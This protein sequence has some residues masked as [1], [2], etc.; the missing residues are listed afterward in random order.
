MTVEKHQQAETYLSQRKLAAAYEICQQILAKSPNF[1]PAYNTQGKILQA[2]GKIESAIAS[3]RQ[4]IKLNPHQIETYKILGDILVEQKQL[5]QAIIWYKTAIKFHP[6]FSL[7]YHKLGSV[8]M[9]Q[10][11]WDEAVDAF[12]RA[13]QLNPNFAWSYQ[14]LGEALAQQKKWHQAV[15]AYQRAIEIKPDLDGSYRHLGNALIKQGKINEAIAYYQDSIKRQPN[16][17]I[18]HKLLADALE[19]QG[20]L[21]AAITSYLRAIEL[22]PDSPWSHICLWKVL[23]KKD[24]WDEAVIIY[25]QAIEFNP[26]G[27]WLW[28]YL[29]NALVKQGKLEAAITCYQKA[30]EL[31]PENS[32]I[33]RFLADAFVKNNQWEAAANAYLRAIQINPE[34]SWADRGL[35]S[36]FKTLENANKFDEAV[37]L[38]RQKIA[39]NPESVLSYINLGEILTEQ[40]KINQAI[41]CYQT[42]CYQQTLK[43]HPN[44][45]QNYWNVEQLRRPDFIIIGVGKAGTTSLYSYLTQHPQVLP[46]IVKEVKFWSG[47]FERGIDWYL[48]HFPPTPKAEKYLTGEASP[49]Y[50]G[51]PEA[52]TRIF[53]FFPK[54]KLILLLRNPVD[55]AISNYYH[56]VRLNK[57]NRSF[58]TAI[59]YEL[60]NLQNFS[61]NDSHQNLYY[62]P[63]GVYIKFLQKWMAIFPKEQFLILKTED[64]NANPA[65]TM[66]QV[67]KFLD[68]PDYQI[69]DYQKL[70]IGYYPNIKDSIRQKMTDLYRPHNQKLEQFLN[71]KFN[72]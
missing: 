47:Y 52:A 29:G 51:N 56:W 13:I 71:M 14:K 45:V 27:F 66:K 69:S 33:Y 9:Q 32:E 49:G 20:K 8:L 39:L 72:W 11:N 2:M 16:I 5:D 42:A 31:Q 44:F 1:V 62:L 22:N 40:G 64:F 60:E 37:S 38:Y 53:S 61:S 54:I 17:D 21:D 43:Y 35:W 63:V 36:L 7:F 70:N 67:F 46:P 3:Y 18:I 6:K 25:R 26:N 30:I 12:C 28:S 50:F 65:N 4:A 15:I 55:R 68:L 41:I 19:K 58:E 59:N 57:E 23:L 10:Q 24:K 48:A 34:I